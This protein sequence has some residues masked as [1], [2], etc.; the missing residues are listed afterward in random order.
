MIAKK[1]KRGKPL[2]IRALDIK[3]IR[4]NIL[5]FLLIKTKNRY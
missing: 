1:I 3:I 2:I 5:E 4:K